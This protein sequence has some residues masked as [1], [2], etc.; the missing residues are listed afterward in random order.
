MRQVSG[1]EE[2][3]KGITL[4]LSLAEYSVQALDPRKHE[5]VFWNT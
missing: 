5:A 4:R 2:E 1:I 3:A